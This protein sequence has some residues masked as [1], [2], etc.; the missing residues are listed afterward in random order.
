[1]K[2]RNGSL[3]LCENSFELVAGLSD[4]FKPVV[5]LSRIKSTL[6]NRADKENLSSDLKAV[7]S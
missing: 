5:I 1:M 7:N 4:T 6:S 3:D 2:G